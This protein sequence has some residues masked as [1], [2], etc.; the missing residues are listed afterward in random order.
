MARRGQRSTVTG[1]GRAMSQRARHR[2]QP[3]TS[4]QTAAPRS[5]VHTR[6]VAV[7]GLAGPYPRAPGGRASPAPD[8]SVTPPPVRSPADGR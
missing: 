4:G 1:A 5:E 7:A 2:P 8:A 6:H 3:V